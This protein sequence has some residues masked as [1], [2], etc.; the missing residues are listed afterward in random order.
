MS[1]SFRTTL[2]RY[3]AQPVLALAL[4]SAAVSCAQPTAV[5][6][7]P[8]NETTCRAGAVHVLG[9]SNV[10]LYGLPGKWLTDSTVPVG[11][12]FGYPVAGYTLEGSFGVA[13]S[14]DQQFTQLLD[15]VAQCPGGEYSH[16][17]LVSAG[18]NDVSAGVFGYVTGAA[19]VADMAALFNR[20][21]TAGFTLFVNPPFTPKLGSAEG[22]RSVA[23]AVVAYYQTLP[24]SERVGCEEYWY[25]PG[26]NS[27]PF[28]DPTLFTTEDD[29][30]ISTAS[31]ALLGACVGP[32]I[33][34]R[35]V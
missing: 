6:V 11:F 23:T 15:H 28:G 7:N 30:H 27:A 24:A 29:K 34:S 33:T 22:G 35:I 13:P 2:R 14:T 1:I 4:L 21:R 16:R 19:A 31:A 12:N 17:V 9:D 26:L 10:A 3:G 32:S 20:I 8:A 5:D 18:G 25:G